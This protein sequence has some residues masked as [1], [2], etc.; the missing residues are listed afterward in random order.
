MAECPTCKKE[1]NTEHGVKIHHQKIH[2]ESL[3]LE[4][5]EC[6]WCGKT[7]QRH[8]SKTKDSANIF[9]SDKCEGKRRTHKWSSNQQPNWSGG[10]DEYHCQNCNKTVLKYEQNVKDSNNI[11]CSY[12]CHGQW[13][14]ENKN[15]KDHWHYRG[16]E[17]VQYGQKWQRIRVEAI[18]RDNEQCQDCGL[19]RDEH[20]NKYDRDLEV[21]HLTPIRTFDDT[22]QANQLSNL[23]T[24]CKSCHIKRE[25]Q[26]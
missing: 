14:S 13:I 18:Q 21:H 7:F 8:K 2:D 26:S 17:P 9:C 11:F 10:K 20:Y 12:E 15:G 25:A 4:K 6:E 16:S 3:A 24:V 23:I 1:L 19:T 22:E 5:Y